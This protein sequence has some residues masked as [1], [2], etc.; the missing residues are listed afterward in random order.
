MV[1][2]LTD[3]DLKELFALFSSPAIEEVRMVY[4]SDS[5]LSFRRENLSDEY[6]LHQ[7]KRE[8]AIDAWRA[9]MLFLHRHGYALSKDGESVDLHGSS[10][11]LGG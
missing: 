8:F 7:A 11:L 9:A 3:S 1:V 4:T 2:Q 10:G 6:D 5:H